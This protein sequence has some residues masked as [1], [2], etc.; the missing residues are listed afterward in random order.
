MG[1]GERWADIKIRKVHLCPPGTVASIQTKS[2]KGEQTLELSGGR[3]HRKDSGTVLCGWIRKFARE[4]CI[5]GQ[6]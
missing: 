1:W 5:L 2:L 3:S 6:D 4:H